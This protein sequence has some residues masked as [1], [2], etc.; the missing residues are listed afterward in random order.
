MRKFFAA[1]LVGILLC[2]CAAEE[3]KQMETVFHSV[4]N[5]VPAATADRPLMQQLLNPHHE[6]F[7]RIKDYVPNVLVDLRYAGKDNFTG[8]EIY[9]FH[10]AYLRYGTV[11]KLSS[12]CE[13]LEKQ[14]LYLKIWDSFRPV[15]AQFRLWEVCPDPTFVA[16]PNVG[17][18]NHSRGNAVDVTMVDS[19]GR[20]V[21]MPSSF[22]DF[23]S[24]ACRDYADC[25]PEAAENARFLETVME[26]HGFSGY[27]GEWWHFADTDDYD[28]EYC[29]DPVILS[30]REISEDAPL[31]QSA[32]ENSQGIL[33]IPQGE[34]V[35]LL[36]YQG[37][38][39]MVEYWGYR[40]FIHGQTVQGNQ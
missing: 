17:F 21:Q 5:T 12:V 23:S 13:D 31:L 10:E 28:V 26:K 32:D 25:P 35:T 4:T 29:F 8:Q 38:F 9:G 3:E 7:V 37:S 1:V 20:E 15:S 19:S 6:D 22:D 27:W 40:G 18:S 36:G 39:A 24:L 16:N 33:V 11:L 2:G 30:Q 34:C 14:G